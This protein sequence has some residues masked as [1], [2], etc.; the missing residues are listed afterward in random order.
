MTVY[1]VIF[2]IL[3]SGKTVHHQKEDRGLETGGAI[4]QIILKCTRVP[5]TLHSRQNCGWVGLDFGVQFFFGL[6]LENPVFW[7]P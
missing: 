4:S 1:W 3:P 5:F 6:G 2:F 7:T